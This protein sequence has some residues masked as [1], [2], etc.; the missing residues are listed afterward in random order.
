[1]SSFIVGLGISAEPFY[2]CTK[3]KTVRGPYYWK[4]SC[5]EIQTDNSEK[6]E[7]RLLKRLGSKQSYMIKLHI[8]NIKLCHHLAGLRW[9]H[10][11]GL[12]DGGTH[13]H[14][15]LVIGHFPMTLDTPV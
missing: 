11:A 1:M 7:L 3:I 10:K 4:A 2:R 5:N 12:R 9:D 13:Y 15:L 6:S 14:A 8:I